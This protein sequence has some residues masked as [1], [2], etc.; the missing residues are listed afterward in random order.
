[1]AYYFIKSTTKVG[2]FKIVNEAKMAEEEEEGYWT[3]LEKHIRDYL[4]WP[5]TRVFGLIPY[6]AN[7]LTISRFF[8]TFWA[9]LDF[10]FYH[11]SIGHQIWFITGAWITDL[12][13]G[14]TA[15]NNDNVTAFGTIADHT[16]DFFLALWTFFL[17]FYITFDLYSKGLFEKLAV[18]MLSTTLSLTIVGMFLVAIGELLLKREKRAERPHQPYFDFWREFLLKDLIT[19]FSARVHTFF[20][21]FGATIYL[22]GAIW[23]YDP[24]FYVG[25]IFLMIQLVSLGI[26]LHETFQA[27]YEGRAYKIRRGL[28]KRVT[29]LEEI[30][31]KRKN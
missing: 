9:A 22:V 2:S 25:A 11:N 31:K 17:C 12:L 15:R 10:L 1:M 29:E 16:A 6:F 24:Y 27:R 21:G 18:V 14:P 19:T 30:F 8:I 5:I 20:T 7:I 23:K 13:D 4:F 3:P 28:E 26:Y